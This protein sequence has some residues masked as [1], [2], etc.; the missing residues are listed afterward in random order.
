MRTSSD[1]SETFDLVVDGKTAKSAVIKYGKG[2]GDLNGLL[3]LHFAA[4]D[5]WFEED[6]EIFVHPKDPYKVWK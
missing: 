3:K 5:A 4:A 2:S 6:E 1:G